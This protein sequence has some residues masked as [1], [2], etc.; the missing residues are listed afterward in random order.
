MPVASLATGALL[1]GKY[2]IEKLL[3][4]GGMGAVYLAE[5]TDIARHVAIK[6]LHAGLGR[7][8]DV[9]KR[10]RQ[11]AR[12]SAAIGH[13]N[14]VDVLDMGLTD[15]GEAFIVMERLEG[16]TLADRQRARHRM[17]VAEVAAVMVEVLD[18]LAAAHAKGFIHRD[19]K[20]EN[21]FLVWKPKWAVKILDF[22]IS[23]VIGSAELAVTASNVVMGTVRYM[24]PEQ[25]KDARSAGVPADLYA[26]GAILYHL[27]AG[28]PPFLGDGYAELI[29]RLLVDPAVPI[30]Q[31]VPDLPPALA[32]MIDRLLAKDPAAR[33]AGALEVRD[34][35][36]AAVGGTVVPLD[37]PPPPVVRPA[38]DAL[39][40]TAAPGATVESVAPLAA[41]AAVE[42]APRAVVAN[43]RPLLGFLALVV[44]AGGIALALAM[45]TS[46]PA[47][48]DAASP[49]SEPRPIDA[50]PA[51]DAPHDAPPDAPPDAPIDAAADARRPIG[52]Q[53]P[54]IDAAPIADAAPPTIDAFRLLQLPGAP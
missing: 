45:R 37:P 26:I 18:G 48:V 2:R 51:A 16:E 25:A 10:F 30:A 19:L 21:I 31:H 6:V 32:A 22:G 46:T 20:P 34:V 52:T 29:S 5:N 28:V 40:P 23:R 43:R 35:L 33:P 41:T 50:A 54:A 12:A 39:A 11:E 15:D 13:P 44:V 53:H 49:A 9:M 8:D 38:F 4:A 42:A 7:D 47:V 14:I 1:A 27:L 17:A 3:G 24:A 36:L